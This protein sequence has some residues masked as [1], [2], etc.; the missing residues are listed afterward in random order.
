M[1]QCFLEGELNTHGTKYGDKVWSR[2]LR[3]GHS[4]TA[5]QGDPSHIQSRNQEAI[6]DAGKFLLTRAWQGSLERLCQSLTNT[7]PDAQ[8]QLLD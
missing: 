7:E 5:P 3:K 1:L 4:E 8:S 6:V 2:D